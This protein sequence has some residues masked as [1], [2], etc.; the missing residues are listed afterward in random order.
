MDEFEQ[1]GH[2]MTGKNDGQQSSHDQ[3]F[4]EGP[5][6]SK[7]QIITEDSGIVEKKVVETFNNNLHFAC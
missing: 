3:S 5:I 2:G 1:S 7:H 6:K 4:P